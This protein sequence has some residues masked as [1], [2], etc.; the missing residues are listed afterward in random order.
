MSIT[1]PCQR[2]GTAVRGAYTGRGGVC[3]PCRA[4]TPNA[5]PRPTDVV[6]LGVALGVM[7]LLTA[8]ALGALVAHQII[9]RV[10]GDKP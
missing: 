8:A 4:K 6:A 3:A 2:C 10:V 7:G 1:A 5:C 9:T